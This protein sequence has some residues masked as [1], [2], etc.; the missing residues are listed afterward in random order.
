[1]YLESCLDRRPPERVN[2]LAGA[3]HERQTALPLPNGECTPECISRLV[4]PSRTLEH[5]REV[6][7]APSLKPYVVRLGL[8]DSNGSASGFLCLRQ[9]AGP[10]EKKGIDG[11]D[12]RKVRRGSRPAAP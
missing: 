6:F 11:R 9:S 3:T 1:M 12:E 2:L 8:R 5:H 4:D 7:V 10:R